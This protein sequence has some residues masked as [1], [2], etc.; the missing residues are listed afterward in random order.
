MGKEEKEEEKM[1]EGVVNMGID[2]IVVW[3]NGMLRSWEPASVAAQAEVIERFAAEVMPLLGG[4][5]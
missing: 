2:E 4:S 1:R 3:H 5:R